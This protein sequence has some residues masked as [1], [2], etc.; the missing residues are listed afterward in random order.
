MK[1]QIALLLFIFI[2]L[3]CSTNNDSNGNL[4]TAV[5]DVDGNVYTTVKIGTQT[6]TQTNL[7]VSHYRNGDVIPQVTDPTAW[8]NF[9]TGA[10]CYYN[11]DP[12]N[13]TIYGKLYNGYAVTD[14]RGLAPTGYHIPT[15]IEWTT[16]TNYLGG[17]NVAGGKM[18]QTG[19]SYWLSPNQGSSNSS[20]F[21]AI[22]GGNRS[23]VGDFRQIGMY[24]QYWSSTE[25]N[26]ENLFYLHLTYIL[27]KA[28]FSS[29][30]KSTGYSIRCIKD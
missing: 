1:K 10:W 19:T 7:N 21:T 25:N 11:N 30:K 28:G 22:P 15:N 9:T 26:A 3:S 20:R 5:T 24:G 17:E 18:K 16:L 14:P 6:W 29:F 27:E 13:G 2:G 8:A 4:S 12:A 23:F